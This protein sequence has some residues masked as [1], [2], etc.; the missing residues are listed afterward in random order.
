MIR[1]HRKIKAKSMRY[2]LENGVRKYPDGGGKYAN[3]TQ[4]GGQFTRPVQQSWF[5]A[6][7]ISAQ[8]ALGGS[9]RRTQLSTTTFRAAWALALEMTGFTMR[10]ACR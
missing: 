1:R 4:Q 2:E 3:T 10:T 5:T 9:T 8:S 7:A 6:K